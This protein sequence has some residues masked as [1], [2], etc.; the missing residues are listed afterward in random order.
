L[1]GQER[2]RHHTGCSNSPR[3]FWSL[4]RTIID[5][6][7]FSGRNFTEHIRAAAN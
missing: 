2:T 4:R 1:N 6:N 7:F 5:K 3:A